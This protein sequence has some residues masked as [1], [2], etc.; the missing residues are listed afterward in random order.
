MSGI[1][2]NISSKD[3]IGKPKQ[4]GSLCESNINGRQAFS[5]NKWLLGDVFL[6][7]VYTVFD[8]D[9]DRIGASKSKREL[10]T[11]LIII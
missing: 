1:A 9:Q 4:D 2:Y 3:Y 7:N 5:K 8:F 10:E 6:K 11:M